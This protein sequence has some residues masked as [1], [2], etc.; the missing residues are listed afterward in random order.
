MDR[1]RAIQEDYYSEENRQDYYS[2]EN[3]QLRIGRI[4]EEQ[5]R[6]REEQRR[7]EELEEQRRVE[8]NIV[9]DLTDDIFI[10]TIPRQV[11]QENLDNTPLYTGTLTFNTDLRL[12]R[13]FSRRNLS[14]SV[15]RDYT[16]RGWNFVLERNDNGYLSVIYRR[17]ITKT[18]LL[19]YVDIDL[20]HR[21]LN[22]DK[23]S[24]EI[25]FVI[26]ELTNVSLKFK[27]PE[28]DIMDKRG[29]PKWKF[30]A[31]SDNMG[32]VIISATR[33]ASLKGNKSGIERNYVI[34]DKIPMLS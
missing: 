9:R 12:T 6:I 27:L 18:E 7:L 1:D 15:L 25:N 30:L 32:Q 8:Q 29:K 10:S 11:V 21:I 26:S 20:I 5:R 33:M 34:R 14:R 16:I 24:D 4:L 2:E 31:Y 23:K 28:L 19:Q 13:D 3:R 22:N 17:I